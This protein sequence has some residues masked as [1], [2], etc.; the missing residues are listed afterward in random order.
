MNRRS[1]LIGAGLLLL[2]A[3]LAGADQELHGA[4][5]SAA[6][7]VYKAWAQ[8]YRKG[9]GRSI[10]YDPVGS[11]AG[12]TQIRQR[13]VDFG[14][15][16]VISPKEELAKDGLVMF[17]TVISGVVPVVNLPKL[18]AP[19]KLS[20]EVLAHIFMGEITQWNAAE[21]VILNP[22]LNLPNL[23]IRVV[24]RS[25]GSGTTYNFSDYL[26]KVSPAWKARFGV[27]SKHRWPPAF[28]TAKGSSEVSAAVRTTSGA[29]GYI[30][31]NYVLEDGLIGV[32]VR[33]SAGYFV[34]ASSEG[35]RKAVLQSRW[36]SSGDFSE[37]LTDMA[38]EKSWPI[39]MGT[40][41]AVP[42][43]ARDAARAM[44][45]L[46]FFVWAYANGDV[47]ATQAKFIPLPEKVQAKA[48]R[49]I[50]SVLGSQ[51]ELIGAEALS[52]LIN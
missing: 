6:A 17:P 23:P 18:S 8:E 31:Y 30:D 19:L 29:I 44:Q 32:Q 36:F 41:V 25:D 45:T 1:L 26:S 10:A 49:E 51:G 52:G 43:V 7:P 37:T 12:M 38:G 22:G 48:F 5:S 15:S 46:R 34:A 13:Q 2:L 3:D 40:Y 11:G 20:G 35:F 27:A 47:L 21:I 28:I 33:N 16:D 39:T 42:R 24:C 14:A 50:Y 4:G 9:G